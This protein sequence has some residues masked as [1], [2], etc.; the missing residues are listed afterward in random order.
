[1]DIISYNP[2]H[3]GAV[4]LIRNGR[5]VFSVE[6]EKDSGYRYSHLTVPELL[7]ATTNLDKV[8]VN[9]RPMS[10]AMMACAP[11]L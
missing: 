3:D 2:G 1:M 8:P 6:A 7:D 10:N 4:C 9:P 11:K 5:L